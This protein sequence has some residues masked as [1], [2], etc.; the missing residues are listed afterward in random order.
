MNLYFWEVNRI[1]TMAKKKNTRKGKAKKQQQFVKLSLK[2][3]IKKVARKLPI[4]ECRIY[5]NW[6][7]EGKT[8]IFVSRKRN[9]GQLLVSFYLVDIW[10]LGLKDSFYREMEPYEYDEIV[11]KTNSTIQHQIGAE[12]VT[13]E[14]AL[15]FNVIY[16]AVEYAE[17]LG[18][19]P[20]KE[21]A[22][23]EYM[24]DDVEEVEYMDI[25]FG[26]NG[27]PF[28]ASGPD[29][30]VAKILNTLNKS[31]GEGNYEFLAHFGP[32][33]GM[34]DEAYITKHPYS[35]R[36]EAARLSDKLEEE[37]EKNAIE[38]MYHL[39]AAD[40]IH[41]LLDGDLSKLQEA[42]E[43]D[44]VDDVVD[45]L[46]E[47][48]NK[49]LEGLVG[50]EE[51]EDIE[52]LVNIVLA[53]MLHYGDAEFL[54]QDDYKPILEIPSPAEMQAMSEEEYK[55]WE[56]EMAKR[57]TPVETY[58][59]YVKMIT[60][61]EI[62][63]AFDMTKPKKFTSEEQLEIANKVTRMFE[64]VKGKSEGE[65]ELDEYEFINEEVRKLL[66]FVEETEYTEPED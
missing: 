58:A 50:E 52:H 46:A 60:F 25:E 40:V 20:A 3:Y 2:A 48:I 54:F 13:C 43:N 30:N 35:S 19:V 32:D 55:A 16:G 10:C 59:H 15:A 7:E 57:R 17:D 39:M 63:E 4:H 36:P 11:E 18:F 62:S 38:Y 37:D 14:P 12:F 53:Q 9:N 23:T 42:Y 34:N 24:L 29:D 6:K 26:K 8:Q 51:K 45:G 41:N 66:K 31:V 22:I 47:I 27:K 65:L 28:Y 21:F 64:E 61:K 33:F 44:I 1:E 5:D 49:D 56:E